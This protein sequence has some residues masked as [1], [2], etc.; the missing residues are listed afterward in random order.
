MVGSRLPALVAAAVLLA[1]PAPALPAQ[2]AFDHGHVLYGTLLQAHL[3]QG[4]VDYRSLKANRA[5]LDAL[6]RA[7]GDVSDRDVQAWTRPQQVAFWINAYN[8][9]T[10]Q[11]IV[12]HYP[13]A[14]SRLSLQPRNSIRQI[15]GV[16]TTLTWKAGGREV[17]LDD[18]EHRILRPVFRE[19]LVHFAINCASVSCPPLAAEPYRAADLQAQLEAAARRFLASPEGLR[20]RDATLS[21]SSLFKWYGEDFVEPFAA[22][23]PTSGTPVERAILGIVSRFGPEEAR[24]AVARGRV[25]IRFLPYDWSLNDVVGGP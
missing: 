11:A 16:W 19:P 13:I 18:I 21:V 24:S 14:G 2:G 23:G 1:C 20:W 25:R 22:L 15:K 6:V 7:F 4:R 10:L 9:F 17:T 8:V 12:D 3:R 5:A